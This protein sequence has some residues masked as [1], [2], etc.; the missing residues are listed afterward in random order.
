MPGPS[1]D[2]SASGPDGDGFSRTGF[3]NGSESGGRV[4]GMVTLSGL[5]PGSTVG[6]SLVGG[7]IV[8]IMVIPDL[9]SFFTCVAEIGLTIGA[10]SPI[11]KS[12]CCF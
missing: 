10:T 9:V 2:G 4:S 12:D 6:F 3:Q 1:G 5:I 7:S 11:A 8:G